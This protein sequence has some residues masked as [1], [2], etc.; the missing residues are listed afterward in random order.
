MFDLDAVNVS[1][2][3]DRERVGSAVRRHLRILVVILGVV[4][5]GD[6]QWSP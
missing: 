4:R 1:P 2:N 3:T 5:A 6:V